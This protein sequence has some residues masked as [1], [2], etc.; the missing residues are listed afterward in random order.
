MSVIKMCAVFDLFAACCSGSQK[1]KPGGSGRGL[2]QDF[3]RRTENSKVEDA[4]ERKKNAKKK[5]LGKTAT[6]EL[7][8]SSSGGQFTSSALL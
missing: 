6:P 1:W 3:E 4:R 7:L 2:K 5:R 8:E